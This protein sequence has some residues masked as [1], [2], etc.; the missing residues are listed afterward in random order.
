MA[1]CRSCGADAAPGSEC[2]M[3]GTLQSHPVALGSGVVVAS[4]PMSKAYAAGVAFAAAGTA[5]GFGTPNVSVNVTASAGRVRKDPTLAA[6]LSLLIVGL[7]Q[8]YNG[9]V[10]KGIVMFIGCVLLWCVFLGWIINIA[11]I[12]DAYKTAE[13]I[14]A[15]S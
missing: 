7:G 4:Q 2:P 15:V 10:G 6:V 8:L 13:K 9:Q 5:L 11:S 12:I 3:C 14:N 1:E